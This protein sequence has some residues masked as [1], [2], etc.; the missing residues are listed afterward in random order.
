MR[1]G[2]NIIGALR[3][4]K[5]DSA[6]ALTFRCVD[7]RNKE[8]HSSAMMVA[9]ARWPEALL[10]LDRPAPFFEE[11]G[12]CVPL[13][14]LRQPDLKPLAERRLTSKK[15]AELQDRLRNSGNAF[16]LMGGGIIMVGD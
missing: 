5:I 8:I 12:L 7:V 10:K 6:Q 4:L 11:S 9:A 16:P 14:V 3:F 15:L 13:A 2:I 1:D